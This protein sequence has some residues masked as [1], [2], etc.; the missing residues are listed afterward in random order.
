MKK[1]I[2]DTSLLMAVG[3]FK[4]DIFSEIKRICDFQYK[5]VILDRQFDELDRLLGNGKDGAAAKLA[6][7][8]IKAKGVEVI[9]AEQGH[10]DDLILNA[11]EKDDVVATVDKNLKKRAVSQGKKVIF[12]RQ[13][14]YLKLIGDGN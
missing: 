13:K 5:L 8:L 4:V 1:I 9:K 6:L 14:K 3:Q 10:V 7:I 12:L 11:A 2:L